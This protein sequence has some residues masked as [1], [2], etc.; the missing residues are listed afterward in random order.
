MELVHISEHTG[1]YTVGTVFFRP[2]FLRPF[3]NTR[4]KCNGVRDTSCVTVGPY[5]VTVNRERPRPGILALLAAFEKMVVT[6]G[7]VFLDLPSRQYLFTDCI[8]E[9]HV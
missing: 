3:F 4:E 8:V 1:D 9:K 2:N 7:H 5:Y 6:S